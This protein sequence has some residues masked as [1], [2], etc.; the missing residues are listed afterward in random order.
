VWSLAVLFLV[1]AANGALAQQKG[2]Q[3]GK[4]APPPVNECDLKTSHFA[5][6]R[7]VLYIQSA[8]SAQDSTKRQQS[9][10]GAHRSLI[11][12]LEQGQSQNPAA[13]YYLGV[14]YSYIGD[15]AGADSAF[16]KVQTMMPTCEKDV[17]QYRYMAWAGATNKGID[18][19]REND[20]DRAKSAFALAN[21]VY[22]KK[23]TALF[24][25]ATLFAT[26]DNADSALHYFKMAGKAAEGDTAETEIHEKATQ[27][28]A[29]I[30]QVLERWDSAVVYFKTF[31]ALHPADSL[32]AK[33]NL[34]DAY[35]ATGD[36]ASALGIHYQ[37]L[38]SVE[39]MDPLDA[40]RE[41][42]AL[43]RMNHSDSAA[44]GFESCVKRL[45]YYRN[46]L[47][48]LTND[49]F[50]LAQAAQTPDSI[51]Y[52]AGKMLPVALRLAQVDPQNR[53]VLRLVAA[54]HQ[55]VGNG[56]STDAVLKR[57]NQM[58]FEVDVQSA[59]TG[60]NGY[61]VQG[62]ISALKPAAAQAVQDS[63]TRDSTQ[64][65]TLKQTKVPAA[66]QAQLQRRQATLQ[67]RL[68][69]LRPKLQTLG[70]PVSVPV[71]T[72]Q[73]LD[74]GGNVVATE[75]VPAQAIEQNRSK[76]FQLSP[77]AQGIVAWRYQVGTA[78]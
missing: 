24:Y 4:E 51:K 22:T 19:M 2:Q 1:G 67:T 64:L 7:A 26:E 48:N 34:A 11:E 61:D 43:F 39:S 68:N 55:F 38:A 6:T 20:Y 56:D 25:L 40:C 29:R 58:E 16:D 52:W 32:E 9:L 17:D 31:L 60:N 59:R 76:Q 62:T 45:P 77:T 41:G 46:G 47:F 14:Y 63:I 74:Q 15:A 50:S 36:T 70:G 44:A 5:I 30:Y 12:A 13:W 10:D 57:V 37:L 33:R 3:K 75:S 21:Q 73:F 78:P 42:V 23:P 65:E 53:G 27:N 54:A 72:F 71:I 18:A 28:V 69:R 8:S 35:A 49:Y 66:Q